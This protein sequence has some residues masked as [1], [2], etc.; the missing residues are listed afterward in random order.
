MGMNEFVA[1]V[2][3]AVGIYALAQMMQMLYGK[4]KTKGYVCLLSYT[5]Y[6]MLSSI[7]HF[8]WNIQTFNLLL[9]IFGFWVLSYNYVTD[10]KKRLYVT[11]LM[12]SVGYMMDSLIWMENTLNIQIAISVMVLFIVN[13]S[14]S[15]LYKYI[16]KSISDKTDNV[17]LEEQNNSYQ[18]QL[19]I[20][21][22]SF[23]ATKALK[24]DLKNHLIALENMLHMNQ[25]D[26]AVEYIEEILK[27][28]WETGN[29]FSGNIVV[30]S[31]L[32]FKMQSAEKEKI[33]CTF[34][35]CIPEQM[36][37]A[38][39]DM[40]AVLGNIFD[41][42]IEAVR[43]LPEEERLINISMQY[44][45]G[46]L[47]ITED[48]PYDGQK[49]ENWET[50]KRDEENHGMGLYNIKKIAKAYDGWCEIEEETEKIF[51]ISVLLHC[52]K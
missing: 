32:G 38:S 30:D 31:I 28:Q 39:K 17:L 16:I 20:M 3:S 42:A 8:A 27:E 45:A 40:V 47:L 2:A 9:S 44:D 26:L 19:K 48:N 37:I 29:I 21:Q 10:T 25:V 14:T 23:L 6:F 35:L 46:C 33:R 50:I 36:P 22:S 18:E 12:G 7:L 13:I 52:C 5:A 15:V 43:R 49:K 34:Q 4:S 51:T 41:N 24:H 11:A 1:C